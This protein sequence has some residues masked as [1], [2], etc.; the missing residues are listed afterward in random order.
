MRTGLYGSG[1]N[2]GFPMDEFGIKLG[3]V[4]GFYASFFIA[5]PISAPY[6]RS[7][8]QKSMKGL[9]KKNRCVFKA[10]ENFFLGGGEGDGVCSAS[11][12]M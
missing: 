7:P 12:F 2:A 10:Q 4:L 6:P 5:N 8:N 11:S 3:V 9:G 1:F